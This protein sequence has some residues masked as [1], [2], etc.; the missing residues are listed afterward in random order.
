MKLKMMRVMRM[1]MKR[2][3]RM[4]VTSKGRQESQDCHVSVIQELVRVT[5]L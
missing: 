2:K 1:R 3:M 4:R 5:F